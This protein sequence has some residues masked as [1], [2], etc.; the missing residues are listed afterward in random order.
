MEPIKKGHQ[1]GNTKHGTTE[2]T[3]KKAFHSSKVLEL[4][5]GAISIIRSS[6]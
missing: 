4:V 1:I 6:G 3:K 2:K 5:Y